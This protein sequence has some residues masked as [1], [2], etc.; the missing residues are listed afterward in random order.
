MDVPDFGT[1]HLSDSDSD[2]EFL[3]ESSSDDDDE[4]D[5]KSGKAATDP[6]VLAL[7]WLE[8]WKAMSENSCCGR[9]CFKELNLNEVT[10]H[11]SDYADIWCDGFQARSLW[12]Q[13]VVS[14]NRRWKRRC[15]KFYVPGIKKD[16]CRHAFYI[17]N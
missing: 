17:F 4:E 5:V 15:E 9:S 12:L 10:S 14:T 8:K 3:P 13:L 11:F 7:K 1:L 16:V 2:S 6:G